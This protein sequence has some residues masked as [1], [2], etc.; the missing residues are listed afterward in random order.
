MLMLF[1]DVSEFLKEI[2]ETTS[3]LDMTA[4][5]AELYNKLSPTEAKELS[6]LLLGKLAPD[7]YGVELGIG[8]KLL[9]EALSMATGWEVEDVEKLYEKMGEVGE[10][11]QYL[12][13]KK[14][15]SSLAS[16]DLA[17]KDVYD[18]LFKISST[19][20]QGSV[21]TK[22]KYAA[23]L[24]N[25]SSPLEAR[26]IARM[27]VNK[28]RAGIG[29]PTIMD[30]LS[31]SKTGTK[32]D[33]ELIERAYNISSDIGEV[34]KAFL[35]GKDL[36][37]EFT[38]E[39]L[40][41]IRPALAERLNSAE[42]IFAKLGKCAVE[43]KYD[44]FRMQ[45]HKKGDLVSIFSRRLERMEGMFPDLVDSIK[46]M[47]Y[48]DIVLEGEALAVNKKEGTFFSF[49]ETMH[50]RRKYGI[51]EASEKWPLH[52]YAFD[53]MYVDGDALID[54]P[55]KERRKVLE[56]FLPFSNNIKLSHMEIAH[57]ASDIKRVFD[58]ALSKKL[59]GIMAKNLE[60]PYKAGK[61]GFSWIKLKKSYGKSVD[62]IDGVVVGY[63]RGSGARA[64][65][66]FGGLLVAVYDSE[67][68]EF[69]TI[70]KVGSGFT[71]EEMVR[72]RDMLSEIAIKKPDKRLNTVV[73]ADVW[74][75]P[76]YVVEVMFDEITKSK[77]HT[78]GN[79]DGQG[80]ALRFPRFL[81]LRDDRDIYSIT[82]VNEVLE[83][84]AAQSSKK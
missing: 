67:R 7:Y 63:Y 83:M 9:F 65:F 41:P 79:I 56:S 40:R 36:S 54:R 81:K 52:L 17:V 4:K 16:R 75:E 23:E 8:M 74:V 71:E 6:Y 26:Y 29:E 21:M 30:A 1:R 14:K 39:V 34:A 45:V 47:P 27:L 55:F 24:F 3:R 77:Q 49:Q 38:I 84:F 35:E 32:E 57:N 69:Q 70:A 20:G 66:G 18:A 11:S 61:R 72:L 59:E 12:I 82:T 13:T 50:R 19:S 15:Q 42:A 62:T 33:R 58:D 2:E 53:V 68:D 31:W 64:K 60:A 37:K 25:N 73:E 5:L 80:Y 10:L 28:L 51:D 78:A 44:G 48:K 76:R 43:Y 46:E 22:I